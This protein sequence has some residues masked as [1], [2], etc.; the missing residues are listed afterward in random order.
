MHLSNYQ[1]D[2]G[3]KE[4][5]TTAAKRNKRTLRCNADSILLEKRNSLAVVTTSQDALGRTEGATRN[6][7]AG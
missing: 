7:N 6:G 5:E 3:A 2:N 4:K 1:R